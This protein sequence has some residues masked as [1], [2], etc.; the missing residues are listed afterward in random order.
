MQGHN[1][2]ITSALTRIFFWCVAQERYHQMKMRAY[3]GS[4]DIQQI[5]QWEATR[6]MMLDEDIARRNDSLHHNEKELKERCAAGFP[7]QR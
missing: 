2:D 3:K 6:K 4:D 1:L 5:N 7:M